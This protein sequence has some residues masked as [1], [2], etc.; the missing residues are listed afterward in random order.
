MSKIITWDIDPEIINLFGIFS[1]RYY[2]LLFVGGMIL[3]YWVVQGIYKRDKL[4][5]EDL[6]HLAFYIFFGTIIGARLGHCL[7]Y[8]PEYYL[9][10]PW[11]MILPFTWENGDFEFTG[12]LG[13]ASH[14]GILAVFIGIWLFC[15]KYKHGFFTTLDKISI[16]G[17]LAGGFIRLANFMNSE[18][19]GLPTGGDYGVIF[20][21]VDNVP[22][23]PAQLY[24]SL[25]YFAIFFLLFFFYRN[26]NW[27][28]QDGF[29]FG[30]FFTLLFFARFCIEYFKVNQVAFE[31]GMTFNM[32]QLLSIIPMLFGIIMM[33][34]NRKKAVGA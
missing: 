19:I 18:I 27:R 6:E 31:E 8:E 23:H 3:G 5:T 13:L 30:L 17:A 11:E 20:K 26:R 33:V 22:R 4:P 25:A 1:L 15:R 10:R 2:G 16:G 28:R 24:E 34:I 29:L 21:R 7:F 14:G 12:F 32:G 9:S